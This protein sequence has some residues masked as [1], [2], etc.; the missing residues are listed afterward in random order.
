MRGEHTVRIKVSAG[1]LTDAI[2][3]TADVIRTAQGIAERSFCTLTDGA[4]VIET[5]S[6]PAMLEISSENTVRAKHL[7]EFLK[8][9]VSPRFDTMIGARYGAQLCNS[10]FGDD[11]AVP[12]IKLYKYTDSFML[13]QLENS[14][15]DEV[16]TALSL[17]FTPETVSQVSL[18]P[19]ADIRGVGYRLTAQ[20]LPHRRGKAQR[21]ARRS[22]L[23]ESTA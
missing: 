23:S 19:P 4:G 11:C 21:G 6:D 20:K 22:A 3:Y 14:E 16:L 12:Q 15:P 17:Y 2:I 9:N 5:L 1:E 18:S 13:K 10:G 8:N 7:V